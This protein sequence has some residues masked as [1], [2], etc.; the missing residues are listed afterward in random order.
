MAKSIEGNELI[1]ILY[2]FSS[3]TKYER[4]LH[5]SQDIIE[6]AENE[7]YVYSKKTMLSFNC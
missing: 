3:L 1:K 6:T 5:I 7:M 4:V 2:K